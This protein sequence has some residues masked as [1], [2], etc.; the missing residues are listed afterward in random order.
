[1]ITNAKYFYPTKGQYRSYNNFKQS[2]KQERK[3]PEQQKAKPTISEA[4]EAEPNKLFY[5]FNESNSDVFLSE[6][7][8]FTRVCERCQNTF[9]IPNTNS[10]STYENYH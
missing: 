4:K 6:S 1:L 3:E 9:V 7:V 5:E 10:V 8:D 2:T